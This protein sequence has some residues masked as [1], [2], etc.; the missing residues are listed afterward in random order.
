MI[1]VTIAAQTKFNQEVLFI[2][3]RLLGRSMTQQLDAKSLD[4]GTLASYVSAYEEF[5]EEGTDPLKAQREAGISLQHISLT[6]LVVGSHEEIAIITGES[7]VA[8]MRGESYSQHTFAFASAT[9]EDWRT[10]IINGCK[11]TASA[12]LRLF[13]SKIFVAIEKAGLTRIFDQYSRK[14]HNDGTFLLESR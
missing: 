1:E 6:F 8:F 3:Q 7:R 12:Q 11:E 9:L 4:F 5:R 13:A 2:V 14:Y 10:V